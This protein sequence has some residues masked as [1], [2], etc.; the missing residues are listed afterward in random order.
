MKKI[1]IILKKIWLSEKEIDIYLD[2]MKH[3]LT[4]ISEISKRTWMHRPDIYKTLPILIENNLIS[5]TIKWKRNCYIAEDPK[6]LKK[7]IENLFSSFDEN[8]HLIE[9]LYDSNSKKPFVKLLMW[10][11]WISFILSDIVN[12]LPKWWILY[13]YSS[14]HDLFKANSYMP[15]NYRTLRDKKEIQRYVISN[16]EYSNNKKNSLDREIVTVPKKSDLFNDN[17]TQFIYWNKVAIIDYTSETAILIESWIIS[18]FQKK[19]F[20]FLYSMLKKKPVY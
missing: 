12:T 19:I 16:E 3:N 14:P 18:H 17:V 20:I 7:L 8:Y 6:N 5:E 4:S 10:G 1:K 11:K 2:V 13:R 15:E 9:E